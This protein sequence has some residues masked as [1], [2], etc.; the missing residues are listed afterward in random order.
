MITPAVAVF[1]TFAIIGIIG[2]IIISTKR[3]RDWLK[4]F[5][6]SYTHQYKKG[7]GQ[8][9]QTDPWNKISAY[10]QTPA[11]RNKAD[12]HVRYYLSTGGIHGGLGYGPC[13]GLDV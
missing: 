5:D 2:C 7:K 13:L 11:Q 4:K 9:V 3:G 12:T 6:Q 10:W 8:L 1:G